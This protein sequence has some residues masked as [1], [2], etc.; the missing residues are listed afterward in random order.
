[1]SHESRLPRLQGV[2]PDG[3][4]INLPLLSE[5]RLEWDASLLPATLVLSPEHLTGA[6]MSLEVGS[7][8][9]EADH[10][11]DYGMIVLRPGACNIVDISIE[12]HHLDVEAKN[13][14]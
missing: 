1:M 9:D 4:V 2:T 5:L 7:G 12:T 6:S 13:Q 8:E 14:D 10:L 11:T 3:Q